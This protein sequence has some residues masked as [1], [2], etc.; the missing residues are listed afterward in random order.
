[1]PLADDFKDALAAWPSGVSVVTTREG[2]LLYGLTVSSFTS[3][4]LDPPLVLVCLKSENRLVEMIR[5][6]G[7]LAVSVLARDQEDASRYFATPGREPTPGFV[8]IPGEWAEEVPGHPPEA[9]L[10]VIDGAAAYVVC[11]LHATVPMGDHTIVVGR[12][13][14][15]R[16]R[17]EKVPLLY[18]RRRYHGLAG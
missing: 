16:T 8:R 4:S 13:L 6:S 14:H 9:P 12:V 18:H 11:D 2:E 7:R 17:P 15:A 1:M 3:V 10:A 5:A